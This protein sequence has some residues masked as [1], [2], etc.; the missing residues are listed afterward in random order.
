MSSMSLAIFMPSNIFILAY[1]T[2]NLLCI[3]VE[4]I[5]IAYLWINTEINMLLKPY[6][7]AKKYNSY[8]V[9]KIVEGE[10]ESL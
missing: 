4:N 3:H 6:M 1:E 5:V 9:V 10:K 7:M 2:L 8:F